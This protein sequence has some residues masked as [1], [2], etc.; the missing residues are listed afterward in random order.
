MNLN[1]WDCQA[2][3]LLVQEAGGVVTDYQGSNS[4]DMFRGDAYIASNGH[5]HAEIR[6]ALAEVRQRA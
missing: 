1:P 3:I 6:R 4:T 5:I 2:G